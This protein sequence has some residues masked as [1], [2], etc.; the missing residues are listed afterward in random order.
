MSNLKLYKRTGN[1]HIRGTLCGVRVRKSTGTSSREHAEA[2]RLKLEKEILDRHHF[3]PEKTATFAEAAVLYLEAGGEARFMEPAIN[4]FGMK[5]LR[6]ITQSEIVRFAAETYPGVSAHALNRQAYTPVISVIRAGAKAGLCTMPAFERPKAPKKK[7]VQYADN[8]WLVTFLEH[9]RPNPNLF[10]IV[11]FLTTTGARVTEACRLTRKDINSRRKTALLRETKNGDPR[12][13]T[14]TDATL[15]AIERIPPRAGVDIVF[16]YKT[17]FSVNQAIERLCKRC[18][19]PYLSSHKIGRHAFAA[20]MLDQ[21]H[22]V[23]MVQEAGGWKSFRMVSDVYGHLEQ[24]KVIDAISTANGTLERQIAEPLVVGDPRL[25][26]VPKGRAGVYIVSSGGFYKVGK[27]TAIER[28]MV[29]LRD[30]SP[31]PVKLH[32][33]ELMP[34]I[35][36]AH[37]V[38]QLAHAL[39]DEYRQ[40]GEWFSCSLEAASLAVMQASDQVSPDRFGKITAHEH[41]LRINA[42]AGTEPLL[43]EDQRA[44]MVGTRGIEPLTPTMSRVTSGASIEA[45]NTE[46]KA[47]SVISGARNCHERA[48]NMQETETEK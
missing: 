19:L 1:W 22:T 26:V 2:A 33:L 30:G 5:R 23:K 45:K 24:S 13:V 18:G 36:T 7:V 12:T 31:L 14:L 3:G 48:K 21:G 35:E 11:L 44:R 38:E 42:E 39:L 10:A 29:S 28:R 17:R 4:W 6:D 34:D 16:G 46:N 15:D 40:S 47:K 27:T 8:E 20:R 37:D 41:F 43:I 9:A 32:H 25:P